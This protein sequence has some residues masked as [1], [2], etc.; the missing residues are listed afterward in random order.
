MTHRMST[1]M[2]PSGDFDDGGDLAPGRRLP[3]ERQL[4]E[5]LEVA[6][7]TTRRACRLLAEED[8]VVTTSGRGTHVADWLGSSKR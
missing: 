3:T 6:A 4:Q 7:T 2:S 1:R 8:L 5:E